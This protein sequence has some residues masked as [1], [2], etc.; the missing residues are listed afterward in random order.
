MKRIF[1]LLLLA[2]SFATYVSAQD[3]YNEVKSMRE[4]YKAT[5][6]DKSK[7]LEERKLAT[8]KFDAIWYMESRANEETEAELGLQVASMIDFVN[9]FSKQVKDAKNDKARQLVIQKFKNASLEN[10]RYN[11]TDK[12]LIYAYVDNQDFLTRFSLDTDWV[13]ALAAVMEK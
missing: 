9:L 8:F 6:N 13:K 1:V 7:P 12:E 5:A 11:D 3:I 2:V 10:A 4:N